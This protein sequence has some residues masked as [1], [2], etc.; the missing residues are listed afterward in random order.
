MTYSPNVPVC[1]VDVSFLNHD[2]FP[3]PC[4][5]LSLTQYLVK[6]NVT[7]MVY[8]CSVTVGLGGDTLLLGTGGINAV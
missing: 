4:S 2:L 3:L 8:W 6:I 1:I 7:E 5:Y